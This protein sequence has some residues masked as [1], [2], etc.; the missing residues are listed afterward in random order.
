MSTLFSSPFIGIRNQKL[1]CHL[2]VS[3]QILFSFP[4]I[5]DIVRQS[6]AC[7]MEPSRQL[8]D[9]FQIME[10]AEEHQGYSI[11]TPE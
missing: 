4:E 2:N 10:R 11:S 3:I 7:N 5:L 9:I 1:T 6:A 8:Y